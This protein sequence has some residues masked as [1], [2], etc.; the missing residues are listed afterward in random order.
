MSSSRGEG[1][2]EGGVLGEVGQ[3]AQLDL[4]VVGGQQLPA[5]LAPA[6]KA[7]RISRPSAVR[8]GMFCRFGSL[9]LSRPV[10]AT[11]WLN[12]VWTRPVAGWISSRQRVDVGVLE[13]G[14]LAVLDDLGRQRVLVG[15]FFEHVGVGAGAGLGLLDDRQLQ[16]L[17]QHLRRAAWARRC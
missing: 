8:I 16:L 11:T 15:E 10:A 1:L 3:H 12:D 9:E 5:G 4:R 17:E 13:L 14:E 7:E 2:A 6:T